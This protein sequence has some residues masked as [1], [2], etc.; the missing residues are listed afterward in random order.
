MTE[1][2]IVKRLLWTGVMAGTTALS[3][4]V[5]IR[6]ATMIWVRVFGEEPPE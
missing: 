5:A 4:F 2:P 3:S 1:S 6:L